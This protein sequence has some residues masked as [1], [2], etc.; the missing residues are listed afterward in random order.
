MPHQH[1][2]NQVEGVNR[3]GARPQQQQRT[4]AD[5]T[6]FFIEVQQFVQRSQQQLMEEI[7]QIKADKTKEKGSQHD[8][9]HVVDKEETP[10]E[11][12]PQ[13]AEQHF[14][15]MIEVATLLEQEKAKVPKEIFY[16]RRPP[17]PPRILSKPYPE[18]YEP[19]TLA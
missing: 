8:L 12:G 2:P 14:I 13:N 7:C 17:Y 11:G 10:V 4:L 1:Q 6:K 9:E 3:A 16:A 18:R 19:R 15:T 5:N